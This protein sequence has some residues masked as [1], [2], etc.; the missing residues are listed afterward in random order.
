MG[1]DLRVGSAR[2]LRSCSYGNVAFPRGAGRPNPCQA[3]AVPATRRRY[4]PRL[5]IAE[6]REQLL[7]AALDIINA[8]GYVAVSMEAVA[9]EAGVSRPVVYGAFA[10]LETLLAELLV[11]EQERA[12]AGLA[13]IVPAE[14][15]DRDPDEVVVASV[16]R[17]LETVAAAPSTWRLVLLPVQGTPDLVRRQVEQVR[18]RILVQVRELVRGGI[19]ARGGP[20]GLDE[21]LVAHTILALAEEGGRLVLTDPEGF[22]PERLTA[23][24]T[25]LLSALER[26]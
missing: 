4:A 9:R 21:E 18:G 22:P 20:A 7:D 17:F 10:N 3:P 6:R 1:F 12:E 26:G 5:P 11:R 23:F 13:E 2:F 15:G 19:V 24:T 14:L 8:R 25:Q 16:H